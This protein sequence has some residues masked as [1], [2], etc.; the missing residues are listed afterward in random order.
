MI[1]QPLNLY[2]LSNLTVDKLEAYMSLNIIEL[3]YLSSIFHM[4]TIVV[5]KFCCLHIE[6]IISRDFARILLSR[7]I[8]ELYFPSFSVPR[9]E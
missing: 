7:N 5:I 2:L 1:F 4:K 6:K 3:F 9:Q 8:T